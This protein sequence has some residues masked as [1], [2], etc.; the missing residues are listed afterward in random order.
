MAQD[1]QWQ[2]YPYEEKKV[3]ITGGHGFIGSHLARA[4]PDAE[5]FDY[6]SRDLRNL[7]D[8]RDFIDTHR[9]EVLFHLAAQSVVTNQDDLE[10][11]STNI[12]GTY[13][14]FHACE[15]IGCL[16]S[17]VH[18]STDKV[19]GTNANARRTDMLR[20]V[21]EPYAASKHCGDIL[22]QCYNAF[23]KLPIRIIRTGNIYG[24][25]DK[26]LDR[27]IPGIIT[28]ALKGLPRK[29]RG[30]PRWIRDFIYVGDLVQAYIRIADE[31]PGVYNLGGE[32]YSLRDVSDTIL[33]LMGREDLQPIWGKT[34]KNEIPFQHIT[35]CPEWWKPGTSLEEGLEKTISW[36]SSQV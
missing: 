15:E 33:R 9:P 29:H 26:H 22:A 35:D 27:L 25:G 28:D 1:S 34:A 12:V 18:V 20:G 6:P 17:I 19:Y 16:K 4:L 31:P 5:L 3:C 7:D 10:S 21:G 14:L 24:E 11:L 8:A 2:E 32:F 13:N 23:Y 30:D 36:Y